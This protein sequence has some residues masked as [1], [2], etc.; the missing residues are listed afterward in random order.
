MTVKEL[1]NELEALDPSMIVVIGGRKLQSVEWDTFYDESTGDD[2]Q[3][4]DFILEAN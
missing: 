3:V 4:V 1:I 2:Y